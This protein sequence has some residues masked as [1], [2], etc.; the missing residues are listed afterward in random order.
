MAPSAPDPFIDYLWI[1]QQVFPVRVCVQMFDRLFKRGGSGSSPPGAPLLRPP[2]PDGH[3][4]PGQPS[5]LVGDINS[6][7]A[8]L[9]PTCT[10][11]KVAA[12]I[13]AF[14]REVSDQVPG[15]Y[16]VRPRERI[17]VMK[18]EAARSGIWSTYDEAV[19]QGRRAILSSIQSS[20]PSY[21]S[22]LRCWAAFADTFLISHFNPSQQDVLAFRAVFRGGDTY[23]RYLVHL[24]FGCKLVGAPEIWWDATVK[25]A[26]KRCK[27]MLSAESEGRPGRCSSSS[28][29]SV[30][31]AGSRFGASRSVRRCPYAFSEGSQ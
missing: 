31:L 10:A 2:A 4:P 26:V 15:P 19:T 18:S 29:S 14:G 22:G 1:S 5:I 20:C 25:A 16:S 3:L 11:W 9:S 27:Q 12:V 13:H 17:R 8:T 24:R 23:S 28:S 7:L 6:T 21:S 30:G